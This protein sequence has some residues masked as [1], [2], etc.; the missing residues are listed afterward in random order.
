MNDNITLSHGS[1]GLQ[2][3]KLISEV[4]FKYFGNDI[5]NQ[6]NDAAQLEIDFKKL[7]FTTDSFVVNPIFFNGGNIGK[8]A[9][10]GTVNDLA[11]SGAKPLYITSAFIIEEGFS[12]KKLEEIVISMADEASNAGVIIV[13]GDTKV[14][15]KGNVDGIF[16]NTSGIGRIYENVNINCANAREG[17]IVIVNGTLGDHGMTIIC[18]RNNL[19]LEG[20]LRSDCACLNSLVDT[21]LEA[22]EGIHVIR[23]ATRGGVA[24]VLNEI[25]EFSNVTIALEENNLPFKEEVKGASE[26]LGLDPLYIANEGK[27]CAFV[28]EA[29]AQKVLGAMRKHPLG[30]NAAII[31]KVTEE[32]GQRVYLNT[33]VGGKRLV[34]MPSGIQLPRIC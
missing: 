20:N 29:Y 1:G 4:F 5:L 8:L 31:G 7:A 17:D 32:I 11:V 16:I 28:P 9:V 12:I 33:I 21:M 25:S 27:L 26:M 24:A 10:C 14:V 19:G 3:N 15:E 34:D 6:M 13:A 22:Y 2:S 30:T 18:Q 23:D